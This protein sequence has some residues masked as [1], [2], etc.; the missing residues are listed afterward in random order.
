MGPPEGVRG[1]TGDAS[2]FSAFYAVACMQRPCPV[3]AAMI[4]MI[5]SVFS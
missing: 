1:Q 2:V 4:M 3:S 5:P